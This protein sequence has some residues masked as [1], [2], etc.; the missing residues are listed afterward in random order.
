M[1]EPLAY[2]PATAATVL[3]LSKRSLSRLISARTHHRPQGQGTHPGRCGERACLLRKP[4]EDRGAESAGVLPARGGGSPAATEGGAIM[5]K[6]TS[7]EEVTTRTLHEAFKAVAE[8][9]GPF[10][11]L[12]DHFHNAISNVRAACDQVDAEMAAGGRT[13]IEAC[14]LVVH[15]ARNLVAIADLHLALR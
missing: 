13:V 10:D 5:T 1:A 15:A 6:R 14:D 9:V 4:A 12:D 3:S 11:R 2:S 8:A 7:K